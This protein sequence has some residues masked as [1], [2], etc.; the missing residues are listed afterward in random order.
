[1][2]VGQLADLPVVQ[3]AALA[4]VGGGLAGEPHVKVGDQLSAPFERFKQ[5][6]RP[7]GPDQ[8]EVGVYLDHRETAACRGNRVALVTVRLLSD[9]EGIE[10]GLKPV[11][12][13]HD[14]DLCGLGYACSRRREV[15]RLVVHGYLD[16]RLGVGYRFGVCQLVAARAGCGSL[17]SRSSTACE[18]P[19]RRTITKIAGGAISAIAP[20]TQ[21]V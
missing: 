5:G 13:D 10:L 21:N 4:L 15:L 12:V 8:R 6:E 7:V 19:V 3:R 14:R 9:P 16:S 11:A 18:L 2:Q 17:R 20:N 1:M